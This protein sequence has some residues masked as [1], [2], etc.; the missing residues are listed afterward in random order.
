MRYLL[1]PLVLS[2]SFL[3]GPQ[4]LADDKEEFKRDPAAYEV[5]KEK[6]ETSIIG[7]KT[8]TEP[9]L[10]VISSNGSNFDLW[11]GGAM[12][13]VWQDQFVL[14][15]SLKYVGNY[16]EIY[17]YREKTTDAWVWYFYPDGRIYYYTRSTG[18]HLF[19]SKA[20]M[21]RRIP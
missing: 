16:G 19:D 10:V 20:K 21:I 6:I 14:V 18:P 15:D 17:V 13:L 9:K 7:L 11:K 2:L 8:V 1:C 3:A 4:L 12:H 5:T